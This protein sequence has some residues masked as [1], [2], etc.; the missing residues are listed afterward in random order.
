MASKAADTTGLKR[1][2]A[3]WQRNLLDGASDDSTA[4]YQRLLAGYGEPHR[5]YHTL[6]HIQHCIGMFE[7]CK[8]LISEPDAL[9]LA[10]WFH[11]VIL[12]AGRPDNEAM[13]AKLYLEISA[14]VHRDEIRQLI[15]R[16]IMATLHNGD[17]LD[18]ADS[19]YMVD[20]DLSSFGLPW[21]HFLRD[22]LNLRAENPQLDDEDYQLNQTGFQRALLARPR[23]FLSDYFH[24][25][26]ERQAR[27]NLARYFE[28]LRNSA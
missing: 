2:Q 26:Y 20:I 3:L 28:Y 1:F 12:V 16:L 18:D 10:I 24:D 19:I 5:H 4:I 9:E 8:Q 7:D 15:A 11:D 23:F 27:D 21:D 17:Q 6:E 25:R 22:S 13:S 14:T